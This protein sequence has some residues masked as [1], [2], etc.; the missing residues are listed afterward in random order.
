[1]TST[2]CTA[3]LT[4]VPHKEFQ[5]LKEKSSDWNSLSGT[6][7]K[8]STAIV[9]LS[10][11]W[12]KV[13]FGGTRVGRSGRSRVWENRAVSTSSFSSLPPIHLCYDSELTAVSQPCTG[14]NPSLWK[15]KVHSFFLDFLKALQA[16]SGR[17]LKHSE[18]LDFFCQV[19]PTDTERLW[20]CFGVDPWSCGYL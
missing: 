10:R 16:I 15:E 14:V 11:Q 4:M 9:V 5:S 8:A 7:V 2:S 6:I 17:N 12:V 20:H 13:G 1:M 19:F 3:A 18:L